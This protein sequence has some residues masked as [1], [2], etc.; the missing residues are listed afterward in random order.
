MEIKK[1][2]LIRADA[3]VLMGTGH[4]M[5]M[6][7]LAQA[8]QDGGGKAIFLCAEITP[9]LE[10]RLQEEGFLLKKIHASSG[11]HEDLQE[12][13][14]LIASYNGDRILVA[15]DGYQFDSSFQQG[16]KNTGCRLLVVD[17]YG[18]ADFYH[19]DF[20]LNQNISAREELYRNR[21]PETQLLLGTKFAL[22]RKEFLRYK[23]WKRDIP[24]T[25]KNVLVTMGGSDPDNV[26]Q[27]VCEA[28]AEFDLEV[29]VVAGGSSPHIGKL[30]LMV[31]SLS[32]KKARFQLFENA[33]NMPELMA[34]ADL[35]IATGGSTAWE[36]AYMGL[37]TLLIISAENQRESS[38]E[39]IKQ[40]Y[41]LALGLDDINMGL[42]FAKQ[43]DQLISDKNTRHE[44]SERCQLIVNG[45]G[46]LTVSEHLR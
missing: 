22:L 34:W 45:I 13:C 4:V 16:L 10:G 5:R 31:E 12:T 3:S 9:A 6:I 40:R 26:T 36:L 23:G 37:P 25:A 21:S 39:M 15:L 46:A 44:L 17:D 19:A 7:A 18:H 38:M 28:L 20:V 14:G 32:A 29:R 24:K 41:V 1:P 11:S 27:C 30:R 8:W 35:A 33:S 43:L 42:G 2:L